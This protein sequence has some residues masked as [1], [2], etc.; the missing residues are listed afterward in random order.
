MPPLSQRG[1]GIGTSHPV[2]ARTIRPT[3]ETTV[4]VTGTERARALR[5][6]GAAV[7][8]TRNCDRS[9]RRLDASGGDRGAASGVPDMLAPA[10]YRAARSDHFRCSPVDASV[11]CLVL[12]LTSSGVEICPNRAHP[13]AHGPAHFHRLTGPEPVLVIAVALAPR[14]A[15]AWGSAVHSAPYPTPER[16]PAGRDGQRASWRHSGALW[17]Y[18]PISTQCRPDAWGRVSFLVFPLTGEPSSR[19]VAAA[20]ANAIFDATGAYPPRA[21]LARPR[22]I[23]VVVALSLSPPAGRR[24]NFPQCP[25]SP[26]RSTRRSR[27]SP[28]AACWRCRA[29]AR[30]RPWRRRERWSGAASSGCT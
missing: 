5:G 27:R 1:L 29:K 20:I 8:S 10:L 4:T 28:T 26:V 18:S 11:S 14:P 13:C 12:P 15:R 30:A 16:P 22:E 19:P 9:R 17:P 7:Q 23:G 3:R 2:V 21:V 24:S 25:R 6:A